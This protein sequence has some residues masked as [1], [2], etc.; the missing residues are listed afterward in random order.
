MKTKS[1]LLTAILSLLIVSGAWAQEKYE[2]A[3]VK[4]ATLNEINFVTAD[5]IESIKT[6]SSQIDKDVIK[7]VNELSNQ[8]WEVYNTTASNSVFIIYYL[9]KKKN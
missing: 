3:I 6:Q 4:I 2:Y 8:G 9:R 5:N 7:K 1:L